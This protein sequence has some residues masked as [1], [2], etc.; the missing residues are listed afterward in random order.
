MN[1]NRKTVNVNADV[2]KQLK[3]Y[4]DKHGLKIRWLLEKVIKDYI[5]EN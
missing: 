3:N 4:C 2:Y 5:N 1:K